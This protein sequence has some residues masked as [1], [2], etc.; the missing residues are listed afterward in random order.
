[1]EAAAALR[2]LADADLPA[3]RLVSFAGAGCYDTTSR[4][5]STRAPAPRALHGYTPY[6]P[7]S[8]RARSRTLRVSDDGL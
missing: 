8:V 5:S 4:R 6:Q 3:T 1:M 2:A 7:R